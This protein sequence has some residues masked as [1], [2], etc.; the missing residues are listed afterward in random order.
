MRIHIPGLIL[1]LL[2]GTFS[3]GQG[4]REYFDLTK[5]REECEILH[6][7][8]LTKLS[9]LSQSPAAPSM[10]YHPD[11]SSFY[12]PG[13]GM[14][15]VISRFE[16]PALMSSFPVTSPD[17]LT[18]LNLK[19]MMLNNELLSRTNQLVYTMRL[20]GH[21]TAPVLQ[22][23]GTGSD[24]GSNSNPE[25]DGGSRSGEDTAQAPRASQVKNP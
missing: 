21:A 23:F 16:L 14:V 12:L 8:I 22:K 11:I 15:F 4:T 5:S 9:H 7:I 24:A 17:S 2:L 3:W 25:A 20:G 6:E 19:M 10:N 1:L 13:E 18:E